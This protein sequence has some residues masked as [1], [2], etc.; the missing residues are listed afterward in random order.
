MKKMNVLL[1]KP[2]KYPEKVTIDNKLECLQESVEGCIQVTYPFDDPVGIIVNEEGKVNGLPLN[3]ALYDE[4][5]E[6]RDVYAGNMLI[7]GLEEENFGSLPEKL[8][9]KYEKMFHNPEMFISV[10]MGEKTKIIVVQM[11][12]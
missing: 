12:G 3:R 2:D 10:P 9:D 6:I 5:G 4:K 1:I 7:V 8:C 11:A